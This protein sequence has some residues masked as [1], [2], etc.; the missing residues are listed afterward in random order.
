MVRLNLFRKWVFG[1]LIFI[2]VLTVCLW[3]ETRKGIYMSVRIESQTEHLQLWKRVKMKSGMGQN[4]T[5]NDTGKVTLSNEKSEVKCT[6]IDPKPMKIKVWNKYS[7]SQL[8]PRLQM[9]IKRYLKM[10]KFQVKYT[11]PKNTAY[12]SPEQLL[13]QLQKKVDFRMITASDAPFNTPEWETYLPKTN[14]SVELGKL[15]RCAVVSSAGS[16]KDSHLG[17]EIG[18]Y[19]CI[20]L[21][22][23]KQL[24]MIKMF[25]C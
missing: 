23:Q 2:L 20:F 13:C 11:G 4:K 25:S 7:S 5:V 1:I 15:G 19:L 10:N 21:L 22:Q 16:I 17:A 3:K 24:N 14:I 9:A 18:L 12:L 6:N 8:N